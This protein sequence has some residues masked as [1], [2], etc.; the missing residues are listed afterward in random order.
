VVAV[1]WSKSRRNNAILAGRRDSVRRET[2]GKNTIIF[3]FKYFLMCRFHFR[4][5]FC[6]RRGDPKER[7]PTACGDLTQHNVDANSPVGEV[8]AGRRWRNL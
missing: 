7:P 8:G 5:A 6:R 3:L 4:S 2:R 1:F